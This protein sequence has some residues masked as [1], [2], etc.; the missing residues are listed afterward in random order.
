[1][2]MAILLALIAGLSGPADAADSL[3][4]EAYRKLPE[5]R[6]SADGKHLLQEPCRTAPARQ[7][8]PRRPVPLIV[9]PTQ[10]MAPA[11]DP[12]LTWAPILERRNVS[13]PPATFTRLPQPGQP[14][15]PPPGSSAPIPVT[16]DPGG[17][18]DASGTF[19]HGGPGPL[20][21]PSGRVCSHNGG[22]MTCN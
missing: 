10:R 11:A 21:S 9:T 6:L 5:C 4:N 7:K 16:C 1:M 17:C 8:M 20:I 14:A 18:R 13:A 12:S 22:W 15:A 19:Y 3:S 2:N